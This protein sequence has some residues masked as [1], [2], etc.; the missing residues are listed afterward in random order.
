MMPVIA[1]SLFGMMQV[2]IGAVQA[3]FQR[4]VTGITAN[5]EKAE[6]W[7]SRN[8][9]LITALNPVIGYQAGAELVKEAARRD[10]PIRQVAVEKARKAMLHNLSDG[11]AISVE[12][13]ERVFQDIRRLTEGGIIPGN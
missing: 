13:I 3:F 4:C 8:S 9:I 7:L 11:R 6:N 12:E 2:M 10:L 5:P 1:H